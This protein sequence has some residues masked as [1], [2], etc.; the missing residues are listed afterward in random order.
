LFRTPAEQT[1]MMDDILIGTSF[2]LSANTLGLA[3]S[4]NGSLT[5]FSLQSNAAGEWE[6]RR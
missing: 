4:I 5:L 2:D 3:D 1:I 6:V